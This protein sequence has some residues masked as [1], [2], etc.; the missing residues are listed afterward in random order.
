MFNKSYLFF[1]TFFFS[2]AL[3][4]CQSLSSCGLAEELELD[5]LSHV[6]LIIWNVIGYNFS[7]KRF[8][9]YR[10]VLIALHNILKNTKTCKGFSYDIKNMI[11]HKEPYT[12]ESYIKKKKSF[13]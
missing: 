12:K 9:Q 11:M 4:S 7:W 2:H 13:C 5:K 3:F 8:E 1:T 6:D 10:S